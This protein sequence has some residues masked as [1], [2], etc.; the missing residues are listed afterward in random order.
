[1]NPRTCDTRIMAGKGTEAKDRGQRLQRSLKAARLSSPVTVRELKVRYRDL[2]G[3]P[4]EHMHRGTVTVRAEVNPELLRQLVEE[5]AAILGL[6]TS[7]R[8]AIVRAALEHLH[9]FA[10]DLDADRR[11][12]E[13][14]GGDAPLPEGVAP[15][16]E[17]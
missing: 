13:F 14:Y 8:A 9:Q 16:G 5:D 7:S 2:A 1:V 6:D 15:A 4:H 17:E 11:I 10:R 12:R 3:K